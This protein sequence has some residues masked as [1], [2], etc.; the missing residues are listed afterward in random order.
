MYL[1][2]DPIGLSGGISLYSYV[3]DTNKWIDPWGLD[4]NY[5]LV[6]SSG[7]VYYH[8][9]ASDSATLHDVGR[10]HAGTTSEAGDVVRFGKG[11]ELIRITDPSTDY[12]IVRGIEQRGIEQSGGPTGRNSDNVRSNRISGVDPSRTNQEGTGAYDRRTFAA[13]EYLHAHGVNNVEDLR[14]QRGDEHKLQGSSLCG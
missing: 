13:D 6:D 7:K 5:V 2:Q 3:H 9:R 8:G 14:H 11:D 10:R 4:W 12:E 1:S